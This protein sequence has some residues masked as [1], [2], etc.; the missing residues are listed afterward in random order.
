MVPLYAARVADLGPDD[1]LHIECGC[2]HIEDL[3]ASML[4]PAGVA[5]DTRILDLQRRLKCKEC[6]WKGRAAVSIRW[7]E[8]RY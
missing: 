5:P 8:S 6:R 3:T 2:G 1:W 4:G 7:A